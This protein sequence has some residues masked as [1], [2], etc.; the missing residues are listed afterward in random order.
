M[1]NVRKQAADAIQKLAA[2]TISVK[3]TVNRLSQA[4]AWGCITPEKVEKQ[5]N[6]KFVQ[7]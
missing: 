1:V 6:K 5:S 3:E 2:N 7:R 4:D